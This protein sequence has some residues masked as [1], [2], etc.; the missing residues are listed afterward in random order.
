MCL[1]DDSQFGGIVLALI[2]FYGV[3]GLSDALCRLHGLVGASRLCVGIEEGHKVGLQVVHRH[4]HSPRGGQRVEPR[5][6]VGQ[7]AP[8]FRLLQVFGVVDQS[9]AGLCIVRLEELSVDLL[10]LQT[11]SGLDEHDSL[12]GI[13]TAD[14]FLGGG[15]RAVFHAN[16]GVDGLLGGHDPLLSLFEVVGGGVGIHDVVGHACPRIYLVVVACLRSEPFQGVVGMGEV[17]LSLGDAA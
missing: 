8:A 4:G 1:V 11:L 16:E 14:V 2:A 3:D 13:E 7:V 5:C 10:S 17:L 12:V 9:D 15:L 6:Q